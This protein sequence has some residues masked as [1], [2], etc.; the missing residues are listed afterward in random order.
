MDEEKKENAFKAW[1]KRVLAA[2]GAWFA[3]YVG[4]LILEEKNGRMV[5]SIGRVMLLLV[6]GI[7]AYFWICEIMAYFQAEGDQ[8]ISSS[9]MPD[10]LYATFA[11]LC[12]YV[13][14]SKVVSGLKTKWGNG[15]P[16]K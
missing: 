2:I 11:A 16:K 6:F 7:M 14:G 3:K 13:F 15:A 12:G 5:I 8:E 4:G 9:A 1:L 10:M